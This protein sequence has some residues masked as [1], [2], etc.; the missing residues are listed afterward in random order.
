MVLYINASVRNESRTHQLALDL[1]AGLGEYTE[2]RLRDMDL[3]PL[4]EDSLAKRTALVD[5]G[6]YSDSM[7]NLAKQFAGAD[8]IVISAPL[9]DGS[10]PALLKIYLEN[11]YV[12]GLVSKYDENG[13]PVGFCKAKKLY[14]V[15][16][17]GGPYVSTFGYD[18]IK[19]LATQCF[20][21]PETELIYKDMLDI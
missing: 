20:G 8:T 21:I 13:Q 18:Y 7:F 12:T 4:S 11:I 14:Y 3:K 6:D 9:Y 17:A 5:A 10:F 19:A 15:S 16:T 1:L 2:L